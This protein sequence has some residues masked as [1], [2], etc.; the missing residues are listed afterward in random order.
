MVWNLSFT[1]HPSHSRCLIAGALLVLLLLPVKVLLADALVGRWGDEMKRT[2]SVGV[3][4][5]RTVAEALGGTCVVENQGGGICAMAYCI[6][7][8]ASYNNGGFMQ[9]KASSSNACAHTVWR[10]PLL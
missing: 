4:Y 2:N 10:G 1:L 5:Q 9:L 6:A 7:P 8:A 3:V